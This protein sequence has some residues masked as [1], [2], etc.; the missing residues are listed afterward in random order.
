METALIKVKRQDDPEDLPY[1]ELF[2]VQLEPGMSVA[3]AIEVVRE[4]PMTADGNRTAPVA[5]ECSC[6]EGLCGACAML[7]NGKARLAC[8]TLVDEFDGPITLEPLAKFP[9]VRDLC[10]DRSRI[11]E[12]LARS[13]C[14]IPLDGLHVAG[15]IPVYSQREQMKTSVFSDCIS[16]GCCSEACPQVNGRSAFAGAFI[17]SHIMALNAH[18]LGLQSR[19]PRLALLGGRGGVADCAGA[20]NC[21]SVCPRGIPLAAAVARLQWEVALNSI[22]RY[23]WG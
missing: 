2:E 22:R 21:E 12:A 7:I 19:D 11:M 4:N 6:M 23:F 17:F 16:C 8:S 3:R 10:V 5:H 15:C 9:L 18:P 1:W 14:W 13:E 20:E